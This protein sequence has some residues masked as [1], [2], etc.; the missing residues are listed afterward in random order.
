MRVALLASMVVLA[1]VGVVAWVAWPDG[2]SAPMDRP[3]EIRSIGEQATSGSMLLRGEEPARLLDEATVVGE[4]EVIDISSP[5]PI[6]DPYSHKGKAEDPYS[7]HIVTAK[8]MRPFKGADVGSQVKFEVLEEAL[9]V[10][11]GGS[12]LFAAKTKGDSRGG[13]PG[14]FVPSIF[15]A[16][17][18]GAENVYDQ[19]RGLEFEVSNGTVR[20][21]GDSE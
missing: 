15:G 12:Y 3:N 8:V 7:V 2:T 9:A 10:E 4:I 18:Q 11:V 21:A 16:I 13:R 5:I 20:P 6:E 14:V 1:L 17:D 19:L